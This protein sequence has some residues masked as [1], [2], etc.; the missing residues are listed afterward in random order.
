MAWIRPADLAAL[1]RPV[2]ATTWCCRG[3]DVPSSSASDLISDKPNRW[4]GEGEPTVYV[5]GDPALALVESGRHPDDLKTHARLVEVDLHVERMIDLRDDVVRKTLD[6]PDDP[7]WILDRGRTRA[8]AQAVRSSGAADGLLVP[9]A[10]A[11]DQPDRW[12]AVVFADDRTTVAGV[13]G[14]PRPSG[15]VRISRPSG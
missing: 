12:N 4:N 13:V 9:S 3:D 8:V 5:S 15:E 7:T 2:R 10:G 1:T 14:A 6:L 11:L